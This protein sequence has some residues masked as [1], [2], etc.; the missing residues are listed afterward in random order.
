MADLDNLPPEIR[1]SVLERMERQNGSIDPT[2]S[3]EVEDS[4]ADIDEYIEYL[5]S[6]DEEIEIDEY[7]SEIVKRFGYDLF[8]D[9][10]DQTPL[11]VKAAPAN[12]ILGP[13]DELRFNFSGSIKKTIDST[14]DREGEV[15]VSE[16][17]SINFSGLSFS[18]AKEELAKISEATLIG[19]SISMS[20][21]NLRSIEIFVTGNAKNPGSYVLNPLSTISN[22]LFNSGG[23][24]DAGSLRNIELRRNNKLVGLYDFYELF[25]KGNT[26]QNLKI[27]S[28]DALLINPVRKSIKIFGEVNRPA[29]YELKE[30][31]N[32]INLLNFAS[33]LKLYA[34]ENRIVVTRVSSIGDTL[35]E[36]LTI[37]E[38]KNLILS[39]GDSVFIHKK[40]L[41]TLDPNNDQLNMVSIKGEV[42]N[43]GSYPLEPGERLSD[44]ILKAGGYNDQAYIEGGIFLRQKVAEKEKEALSATA[45]QLED[46]LVSSITTGSLQDMGDASLALDLLGNIIKRLKDA[47]P[48]GRIVATFDLNQLAKNDDLDLILLDQDQII[49]P[50]KSSTVSVTGQVLAPATFVHSENLSV[51]DYIDLAGG[52]TVSAAEDQLLVILPNGQALRPSSFFKFKQDR[53]LPGSTIIVNRDTTSLSRLSFWRSVLPIFSSLITSLAAIDAIGD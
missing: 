19:T 49:I 43:P 23:P 16:L 36:E 7:G 44:L 40:N 37:S 9:I 29:I 24:T 26:N 41:I 32:F 22:V 34:D 30:D 48:V 46:G 45:D 8:E 10:S 14:I 51:Y 3:P 35:R 42:K 25:I 21:I 53:I 15:F 12:Y 13:G 2:I 6:E 52:F 17:G 31:E 27:Q 38:A 33:G 39:D 50:K 1:K 47:E 18:E 28:G 11:E 5:K 20:L 4:D